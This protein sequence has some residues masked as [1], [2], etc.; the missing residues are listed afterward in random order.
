MTGGLFATLGGLTTSIQHTPNPADPI[1]QLLHR[2]HQ[3][4]IFRLGTYHAQ[5]NTHIHR[6]KKEHQAKCVY[7]YDSDE[8]V[9]HFLLH[10]P[11]YD[12]ARTRLLPVQLTIH[13]MLYGSTT[14]VQRTAIYSSSVLD[15]RDKIVRSL[16]DKK[17]K[18]ISCNLQVVNTK[19]TIVVSIP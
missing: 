17:G 9:D 7:C 6:L 14:H 15:S 1:N 2:A 4:A 13:N 12:N 19:Q 5:V 16:R 3:P 8:T 10:W 11:V 18:Q